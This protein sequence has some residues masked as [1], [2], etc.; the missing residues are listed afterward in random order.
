MA[1][2]RHPSAVDVS[3]SRQVR[4]AIDAGEGDLVANRLRERMAKEPV[5]SS[6]RLDLANHYRERGNTDLALEHYRLILER[7]PGNE[8]AVLALVQTM[9]DSGNA[10]QAALLL[11]KFVQE[12]PAKSAELPAWVGML[13]DDAGDAKKAESAHRLA[14]SLE[15]Q[16]AKVH[17]NLGYNLL[18]QSRREEAIGEFNRALALDS[19]LVIA[20][21]NLALA[22]ARSGL[23]QDRQEALLH[24]QALNG[25]ASAHN[26]LAVV[27]ME[28]GAY[29]EARQELNTALDHSKG[30]LPAIRNMAI[31]ADMD[32]R[33]AQLAAP[34]PRQAR[35]ANGPMR[36]FWNGLIGAG[37]AAPAQPGAVAQAKPKKGE[38]TAQ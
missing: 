36:R 18:T 37:P 31:L 12:H 4:N 26:N 33:P 27:L 11:E 28:Q 13:Y 21:N 24:W 29:L 32:G 34:A 25:P 30:F 35:A 17:N 3:M 1:T 20:R 23:A 7:E 9:R 38:R 19:K 8:R 14:V 16:N 15:Q 22:L 6:L 10:A 2:P 5:N